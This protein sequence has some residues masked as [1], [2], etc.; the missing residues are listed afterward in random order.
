[1]GYTTFS[2]FDDELKNMAIALCLQMN[3]GHDMPDEKTGHQKRTL[4]LICWQNR[5]R[6]QQW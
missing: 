3:A 4:L 1:M 2:V 6:N 5:R